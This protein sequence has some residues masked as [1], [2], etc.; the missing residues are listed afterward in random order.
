MQTGGSFWQCGKANC[1]DSCRVLPVSVCNPVFARRHTCYFLESAAD[2]TRMVG[3]GL[4]GYSADSLVG[5]GKL[6]FYFCH[7]V[8]SR[9]ADF[10]QKA[11]GDFGFTKP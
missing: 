11:T 3:I 8:K 6:L 10:A 9:Q 7:G 4:A 1:R 2:V 5:V